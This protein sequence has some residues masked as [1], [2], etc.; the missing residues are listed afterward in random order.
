MRKTL[1]KEQA[2]SLF[3]SGGTPLIKAT[4]ED[5]CSYC[6]KNTEHEIE[7]S[8]INQEG[9]GGKLICIKCGSARLDKIQGMNAA[10][11]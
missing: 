5:Y 3:K 11:M 6:K 2:D 10:L 7:C 4:K 1:T 9:T 8:D